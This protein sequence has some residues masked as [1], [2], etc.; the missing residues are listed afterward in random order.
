MKDLCFQWLGQKDPVSRK[1]Y[2]GKDN[3]VK[4]KINKANNDEW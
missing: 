3:Q 1:L 4:K 2:Q